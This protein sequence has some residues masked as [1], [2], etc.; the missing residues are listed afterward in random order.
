MGRHG[1]SVRGLLCAF[2]WIYVTSASSQE[3]LPEAPASLTDSEQTNGARLYTLAA[4][5]EIHLRLLEPVASHTHKRGDRFKLEVAEPVTVDQ[6][7]IV[8]AGSP[9]IGEVVHAAKP[10]MSGKAGE[11]ILVARF[12][13]VGE[14][15]VKLR[16][17]VAGNGENRLALATGLGMALG[18]PALF[19]VGKNLV[20]P[21]DTNVYAKV[22]ADTSLPSVVEVGA[23][24]VSQPAITESSTEITIN[25][26]E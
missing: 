6:S 17:F 3:Q 25:E 26:S 12:L 8:P 7:V 9:A 4:G 21:A 14:H 13:R 10:G 24:E 16:S 20:L 23:G 2:L 18:L 22:S 5:T 19:V 11:L 1:H 15:E